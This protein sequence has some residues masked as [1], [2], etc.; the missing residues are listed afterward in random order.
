MSLW[1]LPIIECKTCGNESHYNPSERFE[2][3]VGQEWQLDCHGCGKR[4]IYHEDTGAC[5]GGVYKGGQ[6]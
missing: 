3:V 2:P 6:V 4:L 1:H 5:S